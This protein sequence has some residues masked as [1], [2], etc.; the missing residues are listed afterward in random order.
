MF[1]KHVRYVHSPLVT[2][3]MYAVL[4][5]DLSVLLLSAGCDFFMID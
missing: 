1:L 4:V 5:M 2:G 3:S